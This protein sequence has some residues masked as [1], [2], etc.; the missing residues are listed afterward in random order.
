MQNAEFI[1]WIWHLG[2][3]L[4]LENWSSLATLASLASFGFASFF[5]FFTQAFYC[6]THLSNAKILLHVD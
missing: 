6:M 3:I 2:T 5:F 4:L 1:I